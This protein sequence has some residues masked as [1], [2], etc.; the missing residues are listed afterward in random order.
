MT[1]ADFVAFRKSLPRTPRLERQTVRARGVAFAVFTSPHI[2][3]AVPLV[4]INGGMLYDHSMLWPALSPLAARRQ[5]ILYDQRGRGESG[6][7][8]NPA[9]ATI[10]DDAADVAA[11][12]R[13]LGVRSWDVL[14]HSWG[15]GI[16]MLATAHDLPGVRR[17]VLVDAVGPTSEWMAPLRENV[18][19]RLEGT[20]REAVA[21]IPEESLGAPD[22]ALHSVYARAV[23]PAWFTD[24]EL[25]ARFTPPEALSVTGAAVLARLRRDGYDWRSRVATV[26]VPTL[27]L[28]GEE[29]ALPLAVF[30][31]N[32]YIIARARAEIVPASGHMPFWEAPARFFTLV[33]S[34]LS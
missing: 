6:A 2:P 34:F 12:R 3:G 19:R 28:H 21:H 23:Y 8:A 7:P 1:Y 32:S 14:G 15:G 18:L 27:M 13:A 30:R 22:P 25:A 24:P 16:A 26:T 31:A 11:L 20:Q 5:V 17:L 4:C 10:E 33:E 9:N 29:D